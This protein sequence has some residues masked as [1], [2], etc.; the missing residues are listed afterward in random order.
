MTDAVAA[1]SK[2]ENALIPALGFITVP[3]SFQVAYM[4]LPVRTI[5]RNLK[6]SDV[7]LNGKI[8]EF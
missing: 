4:P 6:L 7:R 2:N 3:R 8:P 1:Q 5:A